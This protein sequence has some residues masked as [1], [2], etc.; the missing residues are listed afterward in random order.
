MLVTTIYHPRTLPHPNE[1][2][3]IEGPW[4]QGGLSMAIGEDGDRDN[5]MDGSQA[6]LYSSDEGEEH[7]LVWWAGGMGPSLIFSKTKSGIKKKVTIQNSTT[8]LKVL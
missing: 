4:P 8:S 5:L 2:D 3:E 7:I 6:G 1:F